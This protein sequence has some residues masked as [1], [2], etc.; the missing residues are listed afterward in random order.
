MQFLE[1]I[2]IYNGKIHLA[3]FHLKRV[4]NT[5]KANFA[6]FKK[7]NALPILKNN[8]QNIGLNKCRIIY[9]NNTFEV[10]F[11]A[12]KK[13]KIQEFV[14]VEAADFIYNY[15][16]AN[17]DFIN[18]H[19]TNY[20]KDC[21]VIF[22]KNG[23]LT[24]ASAYNICLWNGI[25]WHTPTKPLLEGVMRESLLNQKIIIAKDISVEEIKNY[26]KISFINALNDLEENVLK[27]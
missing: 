12:Y 24:D 19:K 10:S 15:K 7:W 21:E 4:N 25:E 18:T 5:L 27:L 17:R 13:Q 9:D 22:S 20:A 11:S 16:F 2:K 8:I 14:I 6:A 23:L 3:N 26:S 1:S